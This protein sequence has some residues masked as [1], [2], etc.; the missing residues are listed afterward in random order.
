MWP[1]RTRV[2]HIIDF[3]YSLI[4]DYYLGADIRMISTVQNIAPWKIG[5]QV[6]LFIY[7]HTHTQTEWEKNRAFHHSSRVQAGL[8]WSKPYR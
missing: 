8:S 3:L 6:M 7:I 2:K 4:N 5:L 1:I